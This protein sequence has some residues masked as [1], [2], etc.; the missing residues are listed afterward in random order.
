MVGSM[1]RP[2]LSEVYSLKFK[3]INV[4]DLDEVKYLEFTMQRKKPSD[5]SA[6]FAN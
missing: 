4:K 5:V 1:L 6:N 2:T 3:D